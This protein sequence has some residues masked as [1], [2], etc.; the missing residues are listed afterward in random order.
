MLAEVLVF[1]RKSAGNLYLAK[2]NNAGYFGAISAVL[3]RE[4]VCPEQ[5]GA[6]GWHRLLGSGLGA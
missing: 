4:L 5:I 2:R 3:T 1:V 6:N